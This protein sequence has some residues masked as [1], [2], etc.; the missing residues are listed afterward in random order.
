MTIIPYV[1]LKAGYATNKDSPSQLRRFIPHSIVIPWLSNYHRDGPPRKQGPRPHA[2]V[3]RPTT[4]TPSTDP[5]LGA[6]SRHKELHRCALWRIFRPAFRNGGL[7]R[8]LHH[9]L[10][11]IN[12]TQSENNLN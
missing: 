3:D 1:P 9:P 10:S 11:N 4:L 12:I 8:I 5:R 6:S 7:T 2:F